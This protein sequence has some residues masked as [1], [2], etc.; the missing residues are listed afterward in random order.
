MP[1]RLLVV[2]LLFLALPFDARAQI[3][4]GPLEIRLSP[5]APG[6][7]QSVDALLPVDGC[8]HGGPSYLPERTVVTRSGAAITMDL[9]AYWGIGCF[10][11]GDPVMTWTVPVSLGTL[12]A[13]TYTLAARYIPVDLPG[14]P[15]FQELTRTVVV[16]GNAAV[17]LPL[18]SPAALGVLGGLL[19][20]LAHRYL[21]IPERGRR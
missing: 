15:P 9:H 10:S 2:A 17:P 14:S 20:L 16:E 12:A 11:A 4:E 19:L 5:N 1:V 18:G 8:F 13:G 6:A 21:R 3:W 7:G